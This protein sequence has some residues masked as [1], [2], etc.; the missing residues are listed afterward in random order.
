MASSKKSAGQG[1]KVQTKLDPNLSQD[2][3]LLQQMGYKQELSR[4]M[5]GFSN[6]AISFSIICIL[7][8]GI[9]AFAAGFSA[10]G[11]AS[12]GIGWPL[13]ALFALIVAAGMAQ[14]ASA[15]PTAGGLYHWSSI[16]GGKGWGW[17][18]AWFNVLGLIFVVSSVNVG[19]WGLFRDLILV[20]IFKMDAA[21]F[22]Y[23]S[24]IIF[25]VIV[26]GLQALLNHFGIRLTT[27]LTDFSGYLIFV[28]A[29]VLT[30]A[31]LAYAPSFDL[32]RLFTFTN[33]TGEAGGNAFPA[34]NS[35]FVAFLSGLILVCYTITGFDASAHTSEET[36]NAASSVPKGMLN[37][38]FWSAL[39][40]YIMICA[41]VLAMPNV[42]EGAAQ[43]YGFFG[44]LMAGSGM[45]VLLKYLL[46]IGI[47]LA[48][49][50][51]AL[52]GLTSTSRML[53]AFARDG[54]LPGALREVHPEHK[55][56]VNAIW[57]GALLSFLA[58]LYAPAFAVLSAGCAVFLYLSYV[59]PIIAGLFAEGK[60][61]THKGPFNLGSW[62]KPI[63][64]LAILGGVLLA[65]VGSKPPFE[66]VGYLVLGLSLVLALVWF[67]IEA[68]RFQGPPAAKFDD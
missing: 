55:T 49:F 66:K 38:V 14:I 22:G 20:N 5:G 54:G 40:G 7:A 27:L 33:Y 1:K 44:W 19:L 11:G 10:A 46:Y 50:L 13:G 60:S 21:N 26:T 45:P 41:F 16:L 61:W 24:Q 23:W 42:N 15:F 12:I 36:N 68:R 3:R 4:R 37:A 35:M 64:V 67:A 65:Y 57:I 62:S 58:T 28:V 48:N 9:T 47:V 30:I 43:G 56:P 34:M 63:A 2:E 51:C 8:G 6:F 59:M 31:L 52:A 32:S 18:T 29:I 25:V 53:Y 17:A 39:F